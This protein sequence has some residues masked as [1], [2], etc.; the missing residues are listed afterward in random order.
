[1]RIDLITAGFTLALLPT[2]AL[3]ETELSS[4]ERSF[5]AVVTGAPIAAGICGTKV[6]PSAFLRI[7]GRLDVDDAD[8][9]FKATLAA[10]GLLG[11]REHSEGDLRPAVTTL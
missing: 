4:N 8:G 5:V 1:M 10:I 3:V 7:A 11:G 9:L 6:I 2:P